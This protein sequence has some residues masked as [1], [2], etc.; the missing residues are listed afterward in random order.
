[1]PAEWIRRAAVVVREDSR[2]DESPSE[3]DGEEDSCWGD[4]R[5]FVKIDMARGQGGRLMSSLF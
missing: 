1:M 4:A 5:G 2:E 3:W